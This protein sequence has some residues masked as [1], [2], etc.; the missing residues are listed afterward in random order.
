MKARPLLAAVGGFVADALSRL[1]GRVM[2]TVPFAH[3][4][5]ASFSIY[6]YG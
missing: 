4:P 2:G 6:R 3:R 5:A 1:S